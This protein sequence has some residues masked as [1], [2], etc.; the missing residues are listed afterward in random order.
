MTERILCVDDEVK[1]LR[2]L[3]RQLHDTYDTVSAEGSMA[4]L[5]LFEAGEEFAVV[6]ADMRM[7]GMDGAQLLEKIRRLS[8]G[9]VRIMLT[10][11]ADQDTAKR[12]V[13]QGRAFRFLSKPCDPEDLKEALRDGVEQYRL[14]VAERKLLEDTLNGSIK[15]LVEILS[16]SDPHSFRHSIELKRLAGDLARELDAE[17]PWEVEVAATLAQLGAVTVPLEILAKVEADAPLKPK[18]QAIFDGIPAA[19]A[20]L[21]E[22]IPRLEGVARIVE[23]QGRDFV[24]DSADSPPLGSRIL[25]VLRDMLELEDRGLPRDQ[26]L[27]SLAN[28][29]PGYDP[30][31]LHTTFELLGLSPRSTQAINVMV[32]KLHPG[33]VLAAPLKTRAG[34]LILR[35][36]QTI[37]TVLLARLRNIHEMHG[38]HE[39]VLVEAPHQDSSG[40]A[41]EAS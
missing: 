39:P 10:G 25:R 3:R 16:I 5:E 36:G 4:A 13:N 33:H 32:D 20:R 11:N 41:R 38:L 40:Q 18:E 19:S 24:P 31:V 2:A 22:N 12:A 30:A 23:L 15:V 28:G 17:E 1:V 26:A 21:I 7:P 35:E 14:Q 29:A 9:T 6:L 34:Q 37:G 8:P 27:A